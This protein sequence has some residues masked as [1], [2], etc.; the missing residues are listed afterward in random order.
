MID[1]Q[2]TR[3]DRHAPGIALSK[4]AAG[5]LPSIEQLNQTLYRDR[6]RARE[7]TI[8]NRARKQRGLPPVSKEEIAA[9]R[10]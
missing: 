2:L 10:G 6:H 1:A 7:L 8:L 3:L 9:I 5:D 4:G